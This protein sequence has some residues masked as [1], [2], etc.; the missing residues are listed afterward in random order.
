MDIPWS[1]GIFFFLSGSILIGPLLFSLVPHSR[2]NARGR[3]RG[4]DRGDGRRLTP[5]RGALQGIT[6]RSMIEL[7]RQAVQGAA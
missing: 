7:A 5:G 6:R 4:K 3:N 1:P 2:G